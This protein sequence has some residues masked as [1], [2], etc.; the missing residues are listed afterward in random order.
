[1]RPRN[2]IARNPRVKMLPDSLG[3]DA[4]EIRTHEGVVQVIFS[5]DEDGWEHVSVSPKGSKRE[6]VQPCPTWRQMCEVKDVFWDKEEGVVQFHPPE[7]HYIHGI[8]DDTNILHLWKPAD[9]DWSKLG[10]D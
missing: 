4:C 3:I 10:W 6:R 2:E 1:M 5:T 7:K 9:N 8:G